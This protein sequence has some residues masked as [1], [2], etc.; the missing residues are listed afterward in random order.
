MKLLRLLPLALL[1]LL[2]ASTAVA[3]GIPPTESGAGSEGVVGPDGAVRFGALATPGGTVVTKTTVSDGRVRRA[4]VLEGRWRVPIVTFDYGSGGVS[5]D[6]STLVIARAPSTYPARRTTMAVLGTGRLHLRRTIEL[7]GDWRFDALS[8]DASTLFLI[9][10]TDRKTGGYAVRAYD[11]RAGRLLSEPIVDPSEPDEPMRGSPMTRTN[12]PGGRW[13]YTLYS[14]GEH[15]FIH[16]LDTVKRTS[17]C[18]DLPHRVDRHAWRTRLV[19]RGGRIH[20]LYRERVMASVARRPE[21]ASAG[22]G[23]P[24]LVAIL[25]ASGLV[26]AAG[27]RRMVGTARSG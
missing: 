25:V 18:L 8:P 4:S 23:P 11:L 7:K 10:I 22:G 6:G 24:W 26:A 17:L 15:P 27:A 16:A 14:G 5:A 9:Q 1:L 21:Q 3:D 20:V 19:L 12:G 2:P 13:V